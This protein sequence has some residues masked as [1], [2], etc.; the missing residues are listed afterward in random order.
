MFLPTPVR[1]WSRALRL[2]RRLSCAARPRDRHRELRGRPA[3]AQLGPCSGC[4]LVRVAR[5]A[6]PPPCRRRQPA[7]APRRTAR[8]AARRRG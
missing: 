4:D 3:P 5:P 2:L 1:R 6:P 7:A 8:P